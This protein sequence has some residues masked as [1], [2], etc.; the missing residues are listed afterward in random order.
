MRATWIPL[1]VVLAAAPLAGRAAG[2][3]EG[4][5]LDAIR[6]RGVLRHLGIRYASFVTG[7]GDGL[8]VELVRRFAQKLGVRYEYVE[9]D[10]PAALPDLVGR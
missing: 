9:T 2:A 4:G 8:D 3:E 1:L 6:A 10:W 5:D 7:G